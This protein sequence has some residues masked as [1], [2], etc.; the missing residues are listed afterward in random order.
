VDKE[1]LVFW[2]FVQFL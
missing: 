2:P 1:T